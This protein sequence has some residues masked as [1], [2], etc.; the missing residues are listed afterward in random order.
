MGPSTEHM[1]DTASPMTEYKTFAPKMSQDI[2]LAMYDRPL[3]AASTTVEHGEEGP[4][5]NAD[6]YL[7][8][9]TPLHGPRDCLYG[10]HSLKFSLEWKGDVTL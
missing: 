4:D 9:P 10:A 1:L 2:M 7:G 6:V 5:G 3:P 8:M